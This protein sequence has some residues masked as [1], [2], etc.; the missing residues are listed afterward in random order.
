MR[1]ESKESGSGLGKP[2]RSRA[3]Q[4]LAESQ[5]KEVER[6]IVSFFQITDGEEQEEHKNL[7]EIDLGVGEGE[8]L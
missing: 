5:K 3:S 4:G 6:A 7:E 8:E 2:R 1:G